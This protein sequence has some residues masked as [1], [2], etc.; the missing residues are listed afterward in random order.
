MKG[1]KKNETREREAKKKTA[2]QIEK[3]GISSLT[4]VTLEVSFCCVCA[5]RLYENT[6]EN[7][8]ARRNIFS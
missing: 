6:A 2:N 8:S 5:Q 4:L 1:E 3:E 7:S